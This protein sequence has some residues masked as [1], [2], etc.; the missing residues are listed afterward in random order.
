MCSKCASAT[1]CRPAG[2][3]E[4]LKNVQ[5]VRNSLFYT[6]KANFASYFSRICL[7]LIAPIDVP[8]L[9]NIYLASLA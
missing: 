7:E 9:M 3:S 1:I 2:Y 5:F 6:F 8:N 4:S